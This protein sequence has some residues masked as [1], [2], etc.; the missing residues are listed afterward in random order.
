MRNPP[1]SLRRPI[2]VRVSPSRISDTV[3]TMILD[4]QPS[5]E[6][7]ETTAASVAS[8]TTVKL[9]VCP[10]PLPLAQD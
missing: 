10:L 9:R 4:T 5:I 2:G 7:V 3:T 6:I 8:L 1:N